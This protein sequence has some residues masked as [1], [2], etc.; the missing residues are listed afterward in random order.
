MLGGKS[1]KVTVDGIKKKKKK[2][3][4]KKNITFGDKGYESAEDVAAELGQLLKKSFGADRIQVIAD[5]D[6]LRLD[7]GTSKITLSVTGEREWEAATYL[8]FNSGSSPD[9]P[10]YKIGRTEPR[11]RFGRRN[12]VLHHQWHRLFL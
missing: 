11:H 2:K 8:G 9:Q 12:A 1:M 6:T 4:K 7:A 3:K 5:G 10:Q